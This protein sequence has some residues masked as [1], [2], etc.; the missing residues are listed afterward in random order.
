MTRYPLLSTLLAL[1]LSSIC[2]FAAEAIEGVWEKTDGQARMRFKVEQGKLNG[3]LVKIAD[4]SRVKDTENPDP[5]LRNRKLLGLRIASGFWKQGDKW[6]GG[7]VYDSSKGKTYKGKI[8]LDGKDKL[9]MRGYV[10][11]AMIGRTADWK[12]VK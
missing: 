11:V 12:R 5:A 2:S 8:W 9:K 1:L 4:K 10:G 3:Y 7:T 6:I